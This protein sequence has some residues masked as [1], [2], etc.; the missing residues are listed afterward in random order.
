N[1]HIIIYLVYFPWSVKRSCSVDW[2]AL[3]GRMKGTAPGFA[4]KAKK[5]P[6][7][8]HK[9]LEEERKRKAD[10]DAARI[11]EEFVESFKAEDEPAKRGGAGFVRGGTVLP[12]SK[13]TDAPAPVGLSSKK[14]TKY[15]PSFLPPS[16]LD[17]PPKPKAFDDVDEVTSRPQRL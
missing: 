9:E 14:S 3:G 16:A 17:A 1:V 10:E 2:I 15:V 4:I 12:G 5:T 8:K 11:Y 7:Q 6:F 13:P